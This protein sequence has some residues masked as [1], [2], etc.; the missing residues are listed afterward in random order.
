MTRRGELGIPLILKISLNQCTGCKSCMMACSLE[1]EGLFSPTL[2][3]ILVHEDEG[4]CLAIATICEHCPRP[5]C[6]PVCP[7]SA[8][9]KEQETGLTRILAEKCNGCGLCVEA[10]PFSAVRLTNGMA[11]I[12]DLCGGKP[13]CVEVCMPGAIQWV[14]ADKTNTAQKWAWAT[15]RIKAL[16]EWRSR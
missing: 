15:E 6:L 4:R 10:C 5:R 16:G 12:C 3:R 14:E 13:K 11:F 2:S 7:T 8:I 1:K 9:V